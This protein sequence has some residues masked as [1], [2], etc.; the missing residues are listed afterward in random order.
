MAI[1]RDM[2]RQDQ[3]GAVADEQVAMIDLDALR[4]QPVDFSEQRL[5]RTTTPLPMTQVLPGW[6][7]PDGIRWSTNL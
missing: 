7:M 1:Q 4:A 3:V 2:I 5:R 6:V